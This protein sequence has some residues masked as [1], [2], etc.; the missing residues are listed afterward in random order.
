MTR[1][2]KIVI[3][4]AESTGKSTIAEGLAKHYNSILIPEFARDYIEKLDRKYTYNDVE[5]IARKQ[6]ETEL[7]LN[8]KSKFVF[9]D[10]WLII[11]KVWFDFVY[12][13]HPD[14]IDVAIYNSNID[15]FLLCDTDIPWIYDHVRENGGN[16]RLILQKLYISELEKYGFNYRIVCGVDNKRLKNAIDIV[17]K[18]NF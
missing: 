5:L 12:K 9:F 2:F 8:N 10:T 16:N 11:T 6:I 13:K 7:D 17:E 15:L 4:G 18:F 14:W 3:T 1:P